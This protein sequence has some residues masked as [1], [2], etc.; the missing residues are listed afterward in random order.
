M[1]L[2]GF[3]SELKVLIKDKA[4]GIGAALALGAKVVLPAPLLCLRMLL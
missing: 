1:G 3:V 2:E 4:S